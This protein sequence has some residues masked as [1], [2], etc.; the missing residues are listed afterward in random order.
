MSITSRDSQVPSK[1]TISTSFFLA[2]IDPH[3]NLIYVSGGYDK[4]KGELS[5]VITV[6]DEDM[7]SFVLP[8]PLTIARDG[9]SSIFFNDRLVICGG[10]TNV[11]QSNVVQFYDP[12]TNTSGFLPPT[13]KAR[14]SFSLIIHDNRLYAVGGDDAETIEMLDEEEG[15]W[16]IVASIKSKRAHASVCYFNS[17]IYFFGGSSAYFTEDTTWDYFDLNTREWYSDKHIKGRELPISDYSN[18]FAAVLEPYDLVGRV[19]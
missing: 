2:C 4:V 8:H 18:G 6:Y 16:R 14:Y 9:H 3:T 10:Y 5:N 13:V 19:F 7:N 1:V 15:R 12:R 11:D 17:R